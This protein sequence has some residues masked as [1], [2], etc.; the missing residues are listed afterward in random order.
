MA[1]TVEDIPEVG[2]SAAGKIVLNYLKDDLKWFSTQIAAMKFAVCVAIKFDISIDENVSLTTAQH[3]GGF[4]K[5]GSLKNIILDLFPGEAPYRKS[6]YLADSGLKFIDEKIRKE[7]WTLD[8]F[9]E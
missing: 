5:D 4:D 2:T 6:Q 9:I 1:D 8:K 3:V 7:E